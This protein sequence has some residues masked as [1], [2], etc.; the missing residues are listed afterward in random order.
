[1]LNK[2]AFS[3][4][5]LAVLMILSNNFLLASSNKLTQKQTIHE[6]IGFFNGIKED[7]IFLMKEKSY[8]I[9]SYKLSPSVIVLYKDEFSDINNIIIHSIVKLIVVNGLVE[10]IVIMEISS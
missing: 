7:T 3:I 4:L 2:I 1:M 6:Y 8:T 10:K 9:A 5:G